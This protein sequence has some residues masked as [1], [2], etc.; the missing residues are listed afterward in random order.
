MNKKGFTLV[1][2]LSVIVILGIIAGVAITSYNA[3]IERTRT[4]SYKNYE[5]SMK[6]S[7]TMYII[8][9]GYKNQ[10]TLN[11]LLSSNKI[12]E[13]NNPKS[14]DKCLSS[15]VLVNKDF[16]DSSNLTYKVCLI[17]PEYKSGGC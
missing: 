1:E 15:Y 14:N 12:D 10:I 16:N 9:N 7:A 5:Q 4:K 6:S 17:C 3:I 2:L 13:F 8:D 11:E